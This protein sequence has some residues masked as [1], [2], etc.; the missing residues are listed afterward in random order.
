MLRDIDLTKV[1]S[2]TKY[3]SIETYH[4]LGEKGRLTEKL[5]FDFSDETSVILTEKVD[6]TNGRIVFLPDGDYMIGSRE[7]FFTARGDRV[8]NP[9]L[10]IVDALRPIADRLVG[11]THITPNTT[12]VLYAE[13]FGGNVGQF[14]K[15]YTTKK[16]VFGVRVFDVVEV[17]QLD[18][19]L[20]WNREQIASWRD[21]GGQSFINEVM[22]TAMCTVWKIDR[23][24]VLN[25]FPGED[26]PTTVEG[27][28]NFLGYMLP[29]TNVALDET[30]RKASEGIV[31]RTANRSKIAK[32]R[33]QDY[34]RTLKI[35]ERLGR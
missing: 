4:V 33:F 20:S 22:L 30:A 7:E 11:H 25:V 26:V 34:D 23:V 27:M 1:N 18:E 19:K 6:G 13:V 32:A 21:H 17:T 31:L 2:L 28:R 5:N 24:P 16:D 3:P 29:E 12:L 8:Y 35:N 15:N 9:M 10:G 14:A